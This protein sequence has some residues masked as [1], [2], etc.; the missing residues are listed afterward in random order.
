M[1]SNEENKVVKN[2]K[3]LINLQEEGTNNE[4]YLNEVA[5]LNYLVR[6]KYDKNDNGNAKRYSYVEEMMDWLPTDSKHYVYTVLTKLNN[7]G[8]VE[9]LDS[10]SRETPITITGKG[11]EALIT[12]IR[13]FFPDK[14][15]QKIVLKMYYDPK[16]LP[17]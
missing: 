15:Q 5:I 2:V 10:Q 4:Y 9:K 8:Y 6:I 17:S 1:S 12:I 16:Y 7:K 14:K 11:E 13:R 3:I